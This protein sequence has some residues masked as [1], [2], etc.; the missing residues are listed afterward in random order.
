LT[1]S[2]IR[3]LEHD[4][5]NGAAIDLP[6]GRLLVYRIDEA[7]LGSCLLDGDSAMT[8]SKR[9][10]P[11]VYNIDPRLVADH[12]SCFM[13]T[14]YY[15]GE[16]ERIELRRLEVD[17][18]G[19]VKLLDVAKFTAIR[20]F[21]G[22]RHQQ[23]KNWTPWFCGGEFM[24]T[25]S[26]KPHRVLQ[27]DIAA[28]E[29]EQVA[30]SDWRGG[31]AWQDPDSELRLSVPPIPLAGRYLSLFHTVKG[32]SY[33]SGAFIHEGAPS[34]RVRAISARPLISPEHAF[35]VNYRTGRVVI[36]PLSM[37]LNG[38]VVTI[39]GG[40]NDFAVVRIT[41]SLGQILNDLEDIKE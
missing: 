40:C 38:D 25:Y 30:C 17:S 23:E 22:Y 24:L 26:M 39:Y 12:D 34:F 11:L 37:S 41:A 9:R 1:V 14:S 18:H 29:C 35:G 3:N 20:G 31:A 16:T 8:S 15:G 4:A 28:G 7:V 10:L 33:Y 2:R 27:V 5:F 32:G 36:F 21:P 19:N 13:T 6:V